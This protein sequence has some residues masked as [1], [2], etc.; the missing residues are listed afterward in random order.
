MKDKY[1]Y[2]LDW[3]NATHN[4]CIKYHNTDKKE[5]ISYERYKEF[6]GRDLKDRTR[7]YRR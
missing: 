2:R 4:Y 3:D 6:G 7:G 1:F 5:I